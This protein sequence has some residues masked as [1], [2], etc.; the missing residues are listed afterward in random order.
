MQSSYRMFTFFF[1]MALPIM[2][3]AEILAPL[4]L[5]R[6]TESEE[7]FF[8]G[9]S[10]W[11]AYYRFLD[12]SDNSESLQPFS[13]EIDSAADL[14][15]YNGPYLSFSFLYR[16]I[17]Q[18]QRHPS[19][20][21]FVWPRAI[22]TQINPYISFELYDFD[23][24][25]GYSHDCKHDIETFSGRYAVHDVIQLYISREFEWIHL[26]LEQA[27]TVMPFFQAVEPEP[28]RYRLSIMGDSSFEL[29]AV[30]LFG[31][32]RA[33]LILR[34]AVSAIPDPVSPALDWNFYVGIRFKG[35]LGD[36][37]L[38]SSLNYIT[39]PWVVNESPPILLPSIG[40]IF[41]G[42]SF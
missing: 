8:T 40:F 38:Y 14:T 5:A 18:N 1:F 6:K 41:H 39:D 13:S 31:S 17:F 19:G 16:N 11:T 37:S 29:G 20:E 9:V 12:F 26:S 23:I 15:L 3:Q 32:I 24:L 27:F 33:S 7:G 35:T 22:I 34:E 28:D 4:P 42:Y 21:L 25:L 36:I 2:L 30:E 10:A